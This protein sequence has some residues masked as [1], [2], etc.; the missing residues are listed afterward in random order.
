MALVL[1][2]RLA[3]VFPTTYSPSFLHLAKAY[4]L[5]RHSG[6]PYHAFAHCKVSVTAAP[7]RARTS[8][9]VSFLGLRL[10]SPLLIVGLV[11]HYL[12]NNLIDRRP[13]LRHKF[14]EKHVQI[15]FPYQVLA[16]VSRGYPRPKGRLS[17]CY[18]AVCRCSEEPHDLHGLVE[19]KI[20]ATSRRIN[21]ISVLIS[22]GMLLRFLLVAI[23]QNY[24]Y[25]ITV[26]STKIS[27]VNFRI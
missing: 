23:L 21:R 18:W 12:T 5:Y 16:S 13:I 7:L 25:L 6:Y 15:E 1:P 24:T 3:P 22:L 8:I 20:A 27:N 26:S 14:V 9:S 17:T 19:S 11:S 10:S 4:T 2:R